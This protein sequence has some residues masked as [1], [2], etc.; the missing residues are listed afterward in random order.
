VNYYSDNSPA[1]DNYCTHFTGV[2]QYGKISLRFV[3]IKDLSVLKAG[4]YGI[5][6]YV[7]S[8]DPGTE[9]DI[10]FIDTKEEDVPGDHPWRIRYKVDS[11]VATWNG[12]WNHIHIPL[13]SFVES[14][15]FDDGQ[16]YA[17]VGAFDWDAVEYFQIVSEYGDLVGTDIYF[18]NI[19]MASPIP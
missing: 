19:K 9:F 3:P 12:S 1:Y 13:S 18:D 5:D 8:N 11:S 16:W 10:R 17:P 15:S 4:N 6:F 7:R 14:G 2:D